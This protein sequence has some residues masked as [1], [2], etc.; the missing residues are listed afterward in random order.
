MHWHRIPN[1]GTKYWKRSLAKGRKEEP[2]N[3]E[4]HIWCPEIL[5]P[6]MVYTGE[7]EW[8]RKQLQCKHWKQRDMTLY[9]M[10][11]L[12]GNQWS[13]SSAVEE[14]QQGRWQGQ[15]KTMQATCFSICLSLFSCTSGKPVTAVLQQSTCE[16]ISDTA[17]SYWLHWETDAY[18]TLEVEV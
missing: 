6:V 14:A 3:S 11:A 16:R 9:S 13:L 7:H 8:T 1:Y 15:C 4:Q 2:W 5:A 18:N 17:R 10:H 12:D